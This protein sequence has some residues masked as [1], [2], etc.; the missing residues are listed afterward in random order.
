VEVFNACRERIELVVLDLLMPEMDGAETL[1]ALSEI[2]PE[3]K[4]VMATG[5]TEDSKLDELLA[6]GA[7]GFVKKPYDIDTL[8]AE[9]KRVQR[10]ELRSLAAAAPPRGD[11]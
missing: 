3:V 8:A 6:D 1:A 9:L 11:R 5:Y 4:V 2:D 7:R 10:G